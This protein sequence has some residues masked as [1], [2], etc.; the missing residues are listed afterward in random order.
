MLELIVVDYPMRLQKEIINSVM[1]FYN[2]IIS[3]YLTLLFVV[4]N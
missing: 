1:Y 4:I 2:T 3:T